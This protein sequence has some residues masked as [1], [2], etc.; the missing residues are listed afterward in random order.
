MLME[1]WM[2]VCL[3]PIQHQ[4]QY[5]AQECVPSS[6]ARKVMANALYMKYLSPGILEQKNLWKSLSGITMPLSSRQKPA[7]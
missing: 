7:F 1:N 6:A 5:T 2:T 3:N 4:K